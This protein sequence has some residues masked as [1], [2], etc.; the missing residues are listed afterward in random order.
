M[1]ERFP[2][3]TAQQR[4]YRAFAALLAGEDIAIDL[5]QAALLIASI[6]YPNLDMAH[7]M[8]QLDALARRVRTLLSLPDHDILPQLPPDTDPFAVLD[9][10]NQVLFV[11]EQFQGNLTD[12]HNPDNSFL[13]RVLDLHTGIPIT[14]SLLY[15]EV[16]RRVGIQIDGIG[17]P[18][19]FVVS[20]RLPDE[21][22]YIDPFEGG[23]F[24]TEQ[25]CHNLVRRLMRNKAA[26]LHAHWFEP[27]THRQLL[28]R[29]L[30]NLKQ[31]YIDKEE[32]QR[33][34]PVCDMMIMLAPQLPFEH[35]DRGILYLQ[36]KRYSRALHDLTTYL[37][38]APDA[39]DRDEI[40]EH[41]KT[42][43]QIIA[44]LN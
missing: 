41:I 15:I 2:K 39:K 7:Y 4:T 22:I 13:N 10:L 35:R 32:Y 17:L 29:V 16:A 9:A 1:T 33:A 28:M 34:L 11:E 5:A 30:N 37:E 12:Y 44:M 25:E 20:Y 6:E 40:L 18:Y 38:M 36:L 8:S 19:H 27:V 21:R 43:R 23:Q 31:I 42:I 26:R 24:M 3:D 14:L